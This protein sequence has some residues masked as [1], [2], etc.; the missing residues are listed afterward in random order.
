MAKSITNTQ[1]EYLEWFYKGNKIEICLQALHLH[2]STEPTFKTD[3]RALEN[4]KKSGMLSTYPEFAYGLIFY[5]V[6]I[7]DK[8]IQYLEERS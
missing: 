3:I 6:T 5:V 8:G 1:L 7:S 4:L 2:Y